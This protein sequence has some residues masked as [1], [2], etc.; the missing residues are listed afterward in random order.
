MTGLHTSTLALSVYTAIQRHGSL[1]DEQVLAVLR[2]NWLES[3]EANEIADGLAYLT[4][5]DMV[6][7]EGGIIAAKRLRNGVA[8]TVIR[9]PLDQTQ[10]VY[11]TPSRARGQ[12]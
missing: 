5:R 4:A 12:G 9:H 6:T 11:G 7:V 1:S 2:Q 3:V 10:L 8:A